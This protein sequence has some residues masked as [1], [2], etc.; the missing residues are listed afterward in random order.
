MFS[1]LKLIISPTL[2]EKFFTKQIIPADTS[3]AQQNNLCIKK[4]KEICP[5][6]NYLTLK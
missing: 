2:P 3:L 4:L 6:S 5:V 1:C